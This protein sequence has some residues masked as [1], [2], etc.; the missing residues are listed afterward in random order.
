MVRDWGM[1]WIFGISSSFLSMLLTG[2]FLIFFVN[3]AWGDQLQII[4]QIGLSRASKMVD[5]S[6]RVVI[7][8]SGG[9]GQG[10]KQ[11][12][13]KLVDS[14]GIAAD[15]Q[16]E[17]ISSGLIVFN[18]ITPGTWRI[19]VADSALAVESVKIE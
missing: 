6:A 3:V 8:I 9:R 10:R 13:C 11:V 4:D 5:D 17:W 1:W 18:D 12:A 7:K 2:L 19:E 16:G 15:H 14:E